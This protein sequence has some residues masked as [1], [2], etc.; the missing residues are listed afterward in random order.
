MQL[1]AALQKDLRLAWR[2][3]AQAAA[4]FAF[5][6][7]TL[8]MFGFA[9]GPDAHALRQL[10]GGFLWIALLLGA[11]LALSESFRHEHT[12]GALEGLLLLGAS[13]RALFLGKATANALQLA[14]LGTALVPVMAV[15]CDASPARAPALLM[16]V[17]LGS[18]GLAA[19]GT[20][21]SALTSQSRG[22]QVLLPLLLLPLAVP[23][24]LAATRATSLLLLGD[25]MGQLGSWLGLL[26]AFNLV[27]WPL[28]ALLFEVAVEE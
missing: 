19:P 14:A 16:V 25:P 8:M 21:Y 5:G 7:V 23:V 9:A 10:A 17:A 18:A 12:Q 28:G 2:T 13:P 1:V 27:F 26:A 4:V 22:A 24:L 3:R 20:L 6:A 15:L 11:L